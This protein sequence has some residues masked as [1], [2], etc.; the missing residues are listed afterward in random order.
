MKT[1]FIIIFAACMALPF[2]EKSNAQNYQTIRSDFKHFFNSS[3][4]IFKAIKTDSVRFVN[5]DSVIYNF[6]TYRQYPF[7]DCPVQPFA[8]SWLGEK[9]I[10]QPSGNNLFFNKNF[11]TITIKT[12]ATVNDSWIVLSLTNGE[13]ITGTLISKTEETI[14]GTTDSV[15]TITLERQDQNGTPITD[16]I[17]GKE[18]R[19]GKELGL[20]STLDFY[21]FPYDTISLNLV[22][23]ENPRVGYTIPTWGDIYDF[24]IGDEF[25]VRYNLFNGHFGS[26]CGNSSGTAIDRKNIKTVTEKTQGVNSVTYTMHIRENYHYSHSEQGNVNDSVYDF[27]GEYDSVIT[28]TNLD[29]FADTLYP[30]EFRTH[31]QYDASGIGREGIIK[32]DTCNQTGINLIFITNDEGEYTYMDSINNGC[33]QNQALHLSPNCWGNF[34][35][36][37][38]GCGLSNSYGYCGD[39]CWDYHR[40]DK[41]VYYKKGSEECGS[42]ISESEINAIENHNLSPFSSTLYPN[43]ANNLATI[44]FENINNA[45]FSLQVFDIIGRTVIEQTTIKTN[46][47]EL[48]LRNL[49]PGIYHYHL[50]SQQEH[51]QSFG[52][53]VVN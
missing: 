28:Y 47:T 38:T 50:L 45:N 40:T 33:F 11:D 4:G 53:F 18:I 37:S 31:T 3:D 9:T 25:H 35:Q 39:Q 34:T 13:K 42:P 20:I 2:C 10:I 48:I 12:N 27:I 24:E 19:F 16:I 17:N 21:E 15:K 52:K 7:Q 49:S 46:R 32:S 30:G 44:D 23:M 51:K 41:L 6:R 14:L 29:Q 8:P 36:F 43:P 26:F 1:I 22:G 5:S